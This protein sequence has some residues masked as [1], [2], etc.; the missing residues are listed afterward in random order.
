[1]AVVKDLSDAT[2]KAWS[3]SD[4]LGAETLGDITLKAC[5]V[6]RFLSGSKEPKTEDKIPVKDLKEP[7]LLRRLWFTLLAR[8]VGAQIAVCGAMPAFRVRKLLTDALAPR[9]EDVGVGSSEWVPGSHYGSRRSCPDCRDHTR[10]T[11]GR[12]PYGIKGWSSARWVYMPGLLP[13]C[14]SQGLR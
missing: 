6:P 11:E 10:P 8:I 3:V 14:S 7:C 2:G 9:A 4:V 12:V 1:M 13:T 5:V